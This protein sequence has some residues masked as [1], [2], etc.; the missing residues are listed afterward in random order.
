M[1]LGDKTRVYFGHEYTEENLRF[2]LAIESD[3]AAVKARLDAVR[4]LR[5]RNEPSTPSTIAEEK[6]TNPFLRTTDPALKAA[7]GMSDAP[8]V[9]VFAELRRRKDRF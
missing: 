9:E 5:A 8:E 4:A 6:R 7:L 3:N 2:A 1:E